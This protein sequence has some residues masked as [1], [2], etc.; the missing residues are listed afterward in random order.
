MVLFVYIYSNA[1]AVAKLIIFLQ[2]MTGSEFLVPLMNDYKRI[3]ALCSECVDS[4]N[5][6]AKINIRKRQLVRISKNKIN[7]PDATCIFP[8]QI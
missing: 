1:N 4:Y 3:R 8:P 2:V 5:L 6:F 7:T